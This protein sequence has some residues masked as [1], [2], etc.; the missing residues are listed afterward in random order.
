MKPWAASLA[1]AAIL[2][3]AM[4]TATLLG[5]GLAVWD[6][7][8]P[9]SEFDWADGAVWMRSRML[10]MGGL[11]WLFFV[12]AALWLGPRL[13]FDRASIGLEPPLR[14]L[15]TVTSG[16]AL[17]A[18]LLVL[19]AALGRVSGGFTDAD[20]GP[21]GPLAILVAAA[22]LGVM[23]L[24]EEVLFR[25]IL[26][27]RWQEQLGPRGAVVVTTILFAIL[28]G[29]NPGVS[30]LGVVGL[31]LAG[32]L[33]AVAALRSGSL[34]WPV[35]IHVGWNAAVG[36]LLGLPVSGVSLP[37][38]L[39]WSP[40]GADSAVGLWGGDFGPEAGVVF[41]T[42]LILGIAI[43][44]LQPQRPPPPPFTGSPQR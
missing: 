30:A 33:L 38:V 3:W 13:G 44:T 16:V 27:R 1:V 10:V 2:V 32:A 31:A 41:H 5:F 4:A 42:S 12:P 9:L 19:P 36:L 18:A 22:I 29:A 26:L 15:R 39:R 17:G 6:L 37:S 28:H 24:G 8:I 34:W 43:V 25:G 21:G 7:G 20:P 11:Q 40:T 23:A 14:P 35:G